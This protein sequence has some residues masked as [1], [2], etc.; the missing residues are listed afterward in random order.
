MGSIFAL[1]KLCAK[2][3]QIV[4]CTSISYA[5]F[6]ARFFPSNLRPT[7]LAFDKQKDTTPFSFTVWVCSVRMQCA[8]GSTCLLFEV[9]KTWRVLEIA[10]KKNGS[11]H[12]PCLPIYS[13]AT[14]THH[15]FIP[16]LMIHLVELFLFLPSSFLRFVPAAHTHSS[17]ASSPLSYFFPALAHHAVH[18]G[19]LH[20]LHYFQLNRRAMPKTN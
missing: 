5:C 2:I 17:V 1:A 16:L 7:F 18:R 14:A 15:L 6:C 11:T 9:G 8:F 3:L 13:P 4:P 12:G 10:G 20:L 19:R